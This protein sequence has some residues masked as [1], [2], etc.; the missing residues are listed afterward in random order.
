MP[1]GSGDLAI[2]CLAVS[3]LVRHQLIHGLACRERYRLGIAHGHESVIRQTDGT[4]IVVSQQ[5]RVPRAHGPLELADS[6]ARDIQVRLLGVGR[7][8]QPVDDPIR[9]PR[10]DAAKKSGIRRLP[11]AGLAGILAPN[12]FD[13]LVRCL[14][15]C[16]CGEIHVDG[17]AGAGAHEGGGGDRDGEIPN[18]C[19]GTLPASSTGSRFT[20]E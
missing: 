10:R 15:G 2:K 11:A 3:I 5:L 9:D 4:G 6:G 19:H 20:L 16:G 13:N 14:L 7:G 1:V 17:H 18:V 12:L 8:D